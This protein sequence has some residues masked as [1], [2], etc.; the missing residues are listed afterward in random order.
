MTLHAD[1]TDAHWMRRC[2]ELAREARASGNTGVGAVLVADGHVVAEAAEETPL[3]PRPF[4]HAEILVVE[5]VLMRT[6]RPDLRAATLYSTAE[7]CVLCGYAVREAGIGRV[8]IARP[9][10]DIGSIRSRFPVLTADWVS[11]WGPPP[12]VVWFGETP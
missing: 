7:P 2:E 3:G 8:V 5:Q 1:T 9:S 6:P 12:D 10:G 11:R 4:A